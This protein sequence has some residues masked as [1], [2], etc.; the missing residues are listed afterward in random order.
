MFLFQTTFQNNL[1]YNLIPNIREVMKFYN[2]GDQSFETVLVSSP[3]R[4]I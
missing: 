3:T 4:G 1:N 2:P